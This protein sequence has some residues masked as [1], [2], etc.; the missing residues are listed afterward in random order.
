MAF[1]FDERAGSGDFTSNPATCTLKFV[2]GRTNDESYVEAYTLSSTSYIYRGLYRQ[3]IEAKSLGGG[4][5]H[6]DVP[7]GEAPKPT[8]NAYR[9]SYDTTGGT[10]HVTQAVSHV[11]SYGLSG[12]TAPN[13]GGAINVA[14]DGRVEG[15]D[16]VVSAFKWTEEHTLPV[17]LTGW[18]YS[19]VLRALTGYVN[20]TT[21]RTFPQGHVLFHGATGSY[22]SDADSQF[23]FPTT[24]QFEYQPSLS[25]VT[26]D[27]ITG[28]TKVGWEYLWFEHAE[29]EDTTAKR[30]KSKLIAVH[31]EKLY[32]TANFAL[33]QIGS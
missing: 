26:Y 3:N 18:P 7:Y 19:Q 29:E 23:E 13:H 27:Q 33:L 21:F 9:I 12:Q 14:P 8:A 2:A 20:H 4:M 6:I 32:E 17:S 11:A 5:W 31:R 28:V 15:V 16:K 1:R 10:A 24:F 22:S 25:S 30:M